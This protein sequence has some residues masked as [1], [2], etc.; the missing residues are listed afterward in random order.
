MVVFTWNNPLLDAYISS[1]VKFGNL[2][3]IAIALVTSKS[4]LHV[5]F[6]IFIV[7]EL[8]AIYTHKMIYFPAE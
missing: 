6:L 3:R 2:V 1:A 5:K 7:E 4:M 8:N